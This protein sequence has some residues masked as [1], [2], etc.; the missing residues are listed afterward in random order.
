MA[1][2]AFAAATLPAS[3]RIGS[4]QPEMRPRLAAVEDRPKNALAS[5]MSLGHADRALEVALVLDVQVVDRG[6]SA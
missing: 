2:P 6:P 5:K 1:K 3:S 4:S